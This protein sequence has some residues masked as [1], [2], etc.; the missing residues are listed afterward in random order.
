M[1][2]KD[3]IPWLP[4]IIQIVVLIFFLGDFRATLRDL[5][6]QVGGLCSNLYPRVTDLEVR[7]K[8]VEKVCDERH[9]KAGVPV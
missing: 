7:M 8:S 5:K 1:T 2:P 9:K 3:I 6:E 4:L